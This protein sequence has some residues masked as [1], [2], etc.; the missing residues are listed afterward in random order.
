MRAPGLTFKLS[1]LALLSGLLL[2]PTLGLRAQET[3]GI[4]TRFGI[5]QGLAYRTNPGLTDPSEPAQLNAR[6]GLSFGIISETRTERLAFEASGVLE[7]GNRR[8]GDALEE[9]STSLSYRRISVQEMLEAEI[10]LRERDVDTLELDPDT[11]TGAIEPVVIDG[12]GTLRQTGGRLFGEFGR[13]S[14]FGGTVTL[15]RTDRRYRNTTDPSLVNS[16]RDSF[17]VTTRLDITEV[18][19]LT[20]GASRSILREE[21]AP[22]QLTDTVSLGTTLDRPDGAWQARLDTTRA[23][24]VDGRR[25]SLSVGRQLD[26][27][28]GALDLSLGASRNSEGDTRLIGEANWRHDLP[29]GR[30]RFGLQRRI[31]G[32][33]RD[34]EV[35]QTRLSLR[36]NHDFTPEIE[37]RFGLVLQENRPLQG[38]D[39]TRAVDLSAGVVYQIDRDWALDSR[40]EHRIREDSGASRRQGTTFLLSLRRDFI[41][42]R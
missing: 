1:L 19:T 38:S 5:E 21:N 18:V 14:P 26:L 10:F 35:E 9:L 24:A 34:N 23:T 11:E 13:D 28:R 29:T 37:G 12:R 8:R 42:L 32:D 27:P 16:D 31:R 40:I 15:S 36:A 25:T 17:G 30:I 20:F 7:F 4:I 39:T 6:T 22:R 33:V 2:W 3:G 41:A